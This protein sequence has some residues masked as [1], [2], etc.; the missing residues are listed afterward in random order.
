MPNKSRKRKPR[1]S[2]VVKMTLA[3]T[4]GFA[5]LASAVFVFG[6]SLLKNDARP[7]SQVLGEKNA[8]IAAD[9]AIAQT[10]PFFDCGKSPYSTSPACKGEHPR[11][12]ITQATLPALQ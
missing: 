7:G 3:A 2:V 4:S 1:K 10:A 11:L 6:F 8:P 9:L 12:H 5:V